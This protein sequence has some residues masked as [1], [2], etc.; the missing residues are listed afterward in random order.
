MRVLFLDASNEVL[1]HRYKSTRRT[2]PLL[3]SNVCNTLEEAISVERQMFQNY[4]DT[5]FLSV[6][7]T[8][9]KASELKQKIEKYFSLSSAPVFSISFISFGYKHGV[10]L[11]ADLMIDVRFLPNPYWEVELRPYSGDDPQVYH[12]VMDKPETK[13]FIKRLLEFLDYAFTEYVKEGKN[14]FTVAIGCTGGQHRSV[15]ITISCMITIRSNITVIKNTAISGIWMN[16]NPLKVVV[17]GGGHGQSVILR[18]IKFIQDIQ[19]SAI[20]T[21]A[22]DGGS[23]GRLRRQFH[24]PAMGDIRAVLIAL[25]ESETLL[26]N[27]MEY[28]FEGDPDPDQEDQGVMGHNLGNL[29]LT[30]LTQSCGS[31]LES[32]GILSKILNVR[33]DIIPAT[34]QVITLFARMADGT[35]VR[36]ES[37]IPN[38]N[39]RIDTVFYQ[40]TVKASEKAVRAIREADVIIYGIGSIFTS[41]LPNLIIP[42]IAEAIRS[43]TL[44]AYICA[45]P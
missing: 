7:T 19:I 6:D 1:L 9:L 25:A 14:H 34:T 11:D 33:G 21:V 44:T 38:M 24:I 22:D 32:I 41:I 31:F 30:A 17:I 37:N 3:I 2:H 39:N 43:R 45:T 4:K 36:G 16:N 13:E 8:F 29:I 28:R 10:P 15:S 42:E 5:A 40:E 12:Y 23:T 26:K 35:I 20:V 27:L 18:G